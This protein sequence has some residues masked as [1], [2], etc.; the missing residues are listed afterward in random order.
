[1]HFQADATMKDYSERLGV[2]QSTV[3]QLADRLVR[4][5]LVERQTDP[6]DRRVVRLHVSEPGTKLL[7]EANASQRQT[8]LAIWGRMKAEDR[9]AVMRGLERLGDAAEGM[10]ADQGRTLP[11]WSER[12]ETEEPGCETAGDASQPVVDLMA[13]RVRGRSAP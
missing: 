2:S 7:A 6:T 1:V 11:S 3:T 13:R 10:R 5:G 8:F 12:S 9:A 4:R